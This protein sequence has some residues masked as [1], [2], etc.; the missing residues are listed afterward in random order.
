M[1][2]RITLLTLGVADL[3]RAVR[4]YRDGLG[5]PQRP[6]PPEVAFFA[7]RGTWLGLFA[8]EALAADATVAAEGSGFRGFTISHN[9]TSPEEV[10]RVLAEAVQAGG[11][12]VKSGHRAEW[13]GYAGYFAD[14]DGFLWEV[15]HNPDPDFNL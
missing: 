13:G 11:T 8:R 7:L 15:A 4:F 1:E 12:L 10:D 5:L 9:V 2:P 3:E 6:S 14:P